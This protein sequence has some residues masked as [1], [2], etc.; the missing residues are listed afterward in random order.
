MHQDSA[1]ADWEALFPYESPYPNQE[2]VIEEVIESGK[3]SGFVACEAACGTGKTLIA[4]VAGVQLVRDP[5]TPFK[6]VLCV[7][8]VKQQLRAFEDDLAAINTNLEPGVRPVSALTLVGKGDLCSYTETGA[9]DP[10]EIYRECER[11]RDPIKNAISSLEGAKKYDRLD[12]FSKDARVEADATTGDRA[13]RIG[14]PLRTDEWASPYQPSIPT[15]DETQYCPFYAD[16]LRQK[17]EDSHGPSLLPIDGVNKRSD[18]QREA[19]NRGVCPHAAMK[20]A[21]ESAEVLVGNYYHV[22]DPR[23]VSQLS[24]PLIGEDTFLVCDEAHMVVPRTRNLLSDSLSPRTIDNAVNELDGLLDGSLPLHVQEELAN[25]LKAADISESDLEEFVGALEALQEYILER[26]RATFDSEV[27]DESTAF[28]ALHEELEQ[29]LRDPETEEPDEVTEWVHNEGLTDVFETAWDRGQQIAEIR[30]SVSDI[31]RGYEVRE[32]HVDGVGRVLTRW[33]ELENVQYF[34]SLKLEK[35]VREDEEEEERWAQVYTAHLKLLNCI[36]RNAIAR[37]LDEFGGG[38]L[39]SATL[40]PLDEYEREVGLRRLREERGRLIR[41]LVYGLNFPERNRA[42][43]I[44]PLS[45]FTYRNRREYD[46]Q[47][48][49]D[50]AG[51]N[52][53]RREYA[54][55]IRTVARQTPGNVLVAMP[56]YTEAVWAEQCLQE[57]GPP[58]EKEILLDESSSNEATEQLKREFFEGES[59]VLVT[60]L[61]GTLTEGVDY[62]GERLKACIVCGVPIRSLAGDYPAA[63]RTAYEDAFGES[64]GFEIAFTIPAVRKARQAVGRVIRGQKETGVRVLADERYTQPVNRSVWSFLPG[65]EQEEFE[66]LP[67]RRLSGKLDGFWE[68]V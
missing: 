23:T 30:K 68:W 17:M 26:A 18:I 15:D 37:R 4:L 27:S 3:R 36:P 6:R 50:S 5:E 51:F 9:I 38:L 62:Q 53:V 13:S 59:K 63:I 56:S 11:L 32:T 12:R 2:A 19:S 42:S 49:P 44:V 7:T 67:L 46:P 55:A 20:D 29:G 1:E 65:H 21:L 8:S 35:R 22:F 48:P 52:E 45:R 33:L 34:R 41:R 16:Y 61:R 10:D 58:I 40:A 60:S 28:A 66:R 31:H 43:C 14:Q 57:A 47:D 54:R 64:R 25:Q 24:N 39:M